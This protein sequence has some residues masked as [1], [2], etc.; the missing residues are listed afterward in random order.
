VFRWLKAQG[1]LNAAELARTYNCGVGMV[2]IV[3]P[4]RAEAVSATLAG[5]GESVRRIGAVVADASHSV[6]IVGTEAAWAV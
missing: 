6:A 2:V 4:E 1:G 5:Q 3:A